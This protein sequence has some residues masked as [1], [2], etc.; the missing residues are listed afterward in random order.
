MLE[1]TCQNKSK[2]NTSVP[3]HTCIVVLQDS[4][5]LLVM[6]LTCKR[7]TFAL[8]AAQ[9]DLFIDKH[10]NSINMRRLCSKHAWLWPP[11]G[12][13]PHHGHERGR[14]ALPTVFQQKPSLSACTTKV[15]SIWKTTPLQHFCVAFCWY[16][17]N[18]Y[19]LGNR[20]RGGGTIQGRSVQ[21]TELE[22]PVG[23]PEAL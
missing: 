5:S 13:L 7:R 11:T 1:K 4:S 17:H 19:H 15:F 18:S 20:G 23:S 8:Q 3:E 21:D 16:V 2:I 14:T 6:H 12:Q 22:L 9:E 10:S